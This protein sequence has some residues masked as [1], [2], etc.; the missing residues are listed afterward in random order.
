M[1]LTLGDLVQTVAF[2]LGNRSDLT[3]PIGAPVPGG[4]TAAVPASAGVNYQQGDVLV[5]IQTGSQGCVLIVTSVSLTGQVLTVF[6]LQDGVGFVTAA[7][8]PTIGG[9]GT[10]AT[11]DITANSTAQPSRIEQWLT[12][13]YINL[14]M[15]N[16]FPGTEKSI[17]FNT[18]QG[19]DAYDYPETVRAIEAL[20]LY[21][22]D[23]T[24]ITVETKDIKSLRRM[25]AV[26]QAAPSMWAEFGRQIVFRPVPDN[27][28]PYQCV[29]DTWANPV[30]EN[31]VSD[32]VILLPDDWIEALEYGATSRGHT[33]IQEEDKAHAIQS[34]LYGF[35]DPQTGKYTPGMIQNLQ[36]R[37]QASAPFK[38]WGMQPKGMTQTYTRKR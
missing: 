33:D 7:G 26:N 3:N 24:V 30:I 28:G 31:P 25:N 19:V 6:I 36:T 34:L 32:T 5:P 21:R 4:V 15:E 8:V 18:V 9:N 10:G 23:G 27:N 35:V 2:K 16:R 38:D 14:A 37:I 20:T 1:P 12:K 13:A 29:L 22:S 17:T 11:F